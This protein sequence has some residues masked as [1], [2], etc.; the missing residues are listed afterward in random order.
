NI[1]KIAVQVYN[2]A[3]RGVFFPSWL[4][5]A[6]AILL[7]E[8]DMISLRNWQPISLIKCDAKLFTKIIT[9]RLRYVIGQLIAPFQ[10]GFM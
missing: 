3:I 10:T 6:L 4:K 9:S 5:T 2:D 7:K 8:G 1:I